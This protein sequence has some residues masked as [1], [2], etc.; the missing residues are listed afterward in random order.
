M[1]NND[2]QL[3]AHCFKP[4]FADIFRKTGEYMP[5]AGGEGA[6]GW[7]GWMASLTQ[8]TWAWVNSRRWWRTGKPGILQSVGLQ[9]RIHYHHHTTTTTHASRT[10]GSWSFICLLIERVTLEDWRT[11]KTQWIIYTYE[12]SI[13]VFPVSHLLS[14]P[15][16]DLIFNEKEQFV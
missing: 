12:I 16:L 13:Q 15:I 4:S 7:D 9:S 11:R 5:Q 2:S 6:R 3:S 10:E 14:L 8:W 1:E